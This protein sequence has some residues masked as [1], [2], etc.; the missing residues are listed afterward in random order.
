MWCNADQ[1]DRHPSRR[2][3]QP[4][5]W[6][7]K[8]HVRMDCEQIKSNIAEAKRPFAIKIVLAIGIGVVAMATPFSVS[9][10]LGGDVTTVQA[11]KE[12][13]Q[14]SLE[15]ISNDR[16]TIHEMHAP[17]SLVVREFVSPAGKV[18]GV[19]WQGPSRPNLQQVL[20]TYF[21]AFTQ[22]AQTQKAHSAGRG[23]I[24]VQQAGLVVQM[25]GHARSFFGKAYVPQMVPAGVQAGEI[26]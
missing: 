12:K 3:A 25:G 22:A 4:E 26:R 9:G 21:E 23:P 19:A 1:A 15:T 14:A 17:N 7:K 10:S 2:G 20:G 6:F 5:L 8:G 13:L 18:F 16:Y 11:D 24:I